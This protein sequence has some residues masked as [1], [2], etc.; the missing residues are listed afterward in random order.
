MLNLGNAEFIRSAA[1]ESDFP[2]DRLPQIVFAG[3]SNVGKSSVIN[4][5]LNRKNFARTGNA[6][7]KTAHINFF[8]IDRKAYVV[9][10]PGYG[11]AKVSKI[12]KERWGALMEQYFAHG[13]ISLGILIV[14]MRH[15]PTA[16]DVIMADWFHGTGVSFLTVA[17]KADKVR[18]NARAEAINLI[19]STL[20]LSLAE[21]VLAFSAVTGEGRD[22]LMSEINVR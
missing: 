5:L 8:L 21:K 4:K 15:K 18:Q 13:D 6:P 19:R 14:D 2:S 1:S 11:F 3:R 16:D 20:K 7:G 10:L 12:E 9:D 17:N 22:E